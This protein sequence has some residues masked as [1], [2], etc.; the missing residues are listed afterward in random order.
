M[1]DFRNDGYLF[2]LNKDY[3]E[4]EI[5]IF[6][7]ARN[8]I[9]SHYQKFIDGGYDDLIRDMRKQAIPFYQYNGL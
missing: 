9:S 6:P 4:I 2:L 8:L 3:S 7:D 5:L 1:F